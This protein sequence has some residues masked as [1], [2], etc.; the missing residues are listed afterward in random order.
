MLTFIILMFMIVRIQNNP[1]ML[2]HLF[3]LFGIKMRLTRSESTFALVVGA[4]VCLALFVAIDPE[5]RVFLMFIDSFG[6]DL[7]V[8]LCVLFLRY[9]LAIILSLL[10]IPLLKVSYRWGPVPGFWPTKTVLKSS[11]MWAGYAVI[12]PATI[13]LIV[14]FFIAITLSNLRTVRLSRRYSEKRSKSYCFIG[15]KQAPKALQCIESKIY[16]PASPSKNWRLRQGV[17]RK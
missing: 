13:L 2:A 6:A 4:V 9:R 8:T 5:A 17:L 16:T 12:Y 3:S 1:D 7:F 10:L 11:A 15:R 14:T